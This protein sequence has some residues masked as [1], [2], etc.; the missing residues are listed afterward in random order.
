MHTTMPH[1]LARPI[2]TRL[3]RAA[4][5]YTI[6]GC[7]IAAPMAVCTIATAQSITVA[8]QAHTAQGDVIGRYNGLIASFLGIPYAASPVGDLRFAPPQ[9]HAA[10]TAPLAAT[11]YGSPC[12]QTDRLNSASTDEDCLFLNVYAPALGAPNRPVMVFIH[13][14]SFNA[15]N[16]GITPPPGGPDYSGVDIANRSGVV[17]VTLNYRLSL[18]GFLATPALDA[19]NGRPS[20]NY[21]LQ[22]QQQALRWVKQNIA[23]FGG[24][25]NNV[26]IFGQSAG[27]ISVLYQLVSPDA[28]GLFSRAILESSDDGNSVTL[29]AVEALYNPVIT[30]LGCDPANNTAACLRAV[31][32]ANFL[33]LQTAGVNGGPFLDGRTVPAA[34][35]ALIG[36]GQFNRVPVVA[37]TTANE[38]SYFIAVATNAANPNAPLT[39]AQVTA[40][41]AADFPAGATQILAAYPFSNYASPAD[42]LATIATDSFFACPTDNVRALAAAYA[43]VYGY[44]FNQPNPVLN[45]PVPSAPGVTR[46]DSHTAELA[47]VFGHNG[48]GQPLSGGDALLSQQI[49]NYW[50]SFAASGNVNNRDDLL[51]LFGVPVAA[52]EN[53]P[54]WP[55]YAAA[56][57]V[58]SLTTPPAP[59]S[60]F[61]AKH[62]CALWASLGYPEVLIES[63]ASP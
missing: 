47:Y 5:A 60:N 44:E 1:A 49:I 35:T 45:F 26:T 7:I 59:E 52:P 28:A 4:S 14:G 13:G 46:G 62:Q 39:A 41:I 22:D 31:P 63:V 29:P 2:G 16:G 12:P 17:V 57:S 48:A 61:A 10:W 36:A 23:A 6:A 20:G 40:T 3:R 18:L 54:I 30:A 37:G 8:P 55:A 58:L 34:P 50:T 51:G 24:D 21:G 42:A 25:P 53:R 32:V 19:D 9:P 38:G 27:G 33:A 43:P 15:G 56:H 11:Q